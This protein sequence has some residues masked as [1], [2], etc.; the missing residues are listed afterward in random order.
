MNDPLPKLSFTEGFF[1]SQLF[2]LSYV[3]SHLNMIL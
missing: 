2:L 1:I 3:K